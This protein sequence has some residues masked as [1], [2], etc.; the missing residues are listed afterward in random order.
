M[1]VLMTGGT[2]FLGSALRRRLE[3]DGHEI[4]VVSRSKQGKVGASSFVSWSDLDS[5]PRDAVVNLAGESVAGIWTARKRKAIYDS[6]IDTTRKVAEWI[7]KQTVKPR[8]F[9]SGS[10]VGIYGDRGAEELTE[11][12]D[13]SRSEGFLAKVCRDWEQAATPAAWKGTRTVLLRTGHVLAP[14]GGFLGTLLPIFRRLPIVILGDRNAYLPWIALSD[15]VGLA[16]G[17]LADDQ[18][19]GPLNMAAPNPATQ[20]EFTRAAAAYLGKRVW[21][22][23]PKG[24]IRLGAGEFGKSLTVSERVVPARAL[25][26][27]YEFKHALIGDYFRSLARS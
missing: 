8:V 17:A 20:E 23:V 13:V 16:M 6:R 15:W 21:G 4:T 5:E 12:T 9:L 10:A 27:G 18:V 24:L 11:K 26:L 2:G 25:E 1:K 19:Q 14:S 22:R 7:D 3:S